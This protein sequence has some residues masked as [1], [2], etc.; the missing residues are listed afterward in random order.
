MIRYVS[1]SIARGFALRSVSFGPRQGQN[2]SK[3]NLIV[4]KRFNVGKNETKLSV[5]TAMK[6][7]EENYPILEIYRG[8]D[9]DGSLGWFICNVCAF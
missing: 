3:S 4:Q 9:F 8:C 6:Y 5:R 1:C 2:L 7:Q